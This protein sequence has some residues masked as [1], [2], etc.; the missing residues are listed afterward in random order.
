[1]NVGGAPGAAFGE[2]SAEVRF[3]N[4]ADVQA[5]LDLSGSELGG[6]I[7]TCSPDPNSQDGSKIIVTGIP[8]G[9]EWQELKDHFKVCGTVAL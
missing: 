6:G 8:R 2:A 1:M 7:I 3:D 9:V 5:A 4:P